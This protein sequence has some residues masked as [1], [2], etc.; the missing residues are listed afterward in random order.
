MP[1]I[2]ANSHL[3]HRNQDYITRRD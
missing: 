1:H 2:A 3:Q